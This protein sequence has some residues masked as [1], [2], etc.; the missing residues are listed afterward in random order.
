MDFCSVF[1]DNANPMELKEVEAPKSKFES[2]CFPGSPSPENDI[3]EV[4]SPEKIESEFPFKSSHA[5][6]ISRSRRSIKNILT[7]K[8]PRRF[9]IVGPCSIHDVKA[10][11]EY[12]EKFHELSKEVSDQF[13]LIMR[14]YFEKPRSIL[15]WK[16][17]LYDPDLDGSYNLAK[18]IR[19]TR[20]LLIALTEM[21][22]PLASELLEI[23]T[24]HYV[25]DFLSWGCIGARTSISPPHRQLASSLNF[26]IGFKNT[27]D[28]NVENSIRA[29]LSAQS[30]HVF[31]GPSKKG[32]LT[33]IQGRGN[34]DCHLVLR[35]G[36]KG[37]NY[38]ACNLSSTKEKCQRAGISDRL[39][40]D[41]SHDNCEKIYSKQTTVFQEII[42]QI[43][44]GN[45]N[46]CGLMLESHLY[47]GAQSLSQNLKYGVSITD[48]CIDWN[49]T[50][51][52]I[53]EAYATLNS[54]T[55]LC[56][57]GT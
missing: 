37:P 27:T 45:Q 32:Y 31:L 26:P 35:G 8:D 7:G 17:F 21:Q 46:I 1:D 55:T 40:V 56:L 20:E 41:C 48:P 24:F 49:C 52:L 18:G 4:P 23:N 28:G 16:G 14:A 9:L 10:A 54:P 38:F 3:F 22:I 39:V 6:F 51:S 36:E 25:C 50:E 19:M 13:L 43:K 33:R 12:A 44:E 47:S 15:G 30:P 53:K 29:I 5:E 2:H 11:R 57:A 34:P 42:Q